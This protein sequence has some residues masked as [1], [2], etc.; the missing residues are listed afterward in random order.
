M[1]HLFT[2]EGN[3]LEID[4]PLFLA[5]YSMMVLAE[6][7]SYKGFH[8]AAIKHLRQ[9][10]QCGLYEAKEIV[11]CIRDHARYD[12]GQTTVV[13]HYRQPVLYTPMYN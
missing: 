2:V 6:E 10:K 7:P 8:M 9:V 13:L 3:T 11:H 12:E 5:I 1:R 4:H